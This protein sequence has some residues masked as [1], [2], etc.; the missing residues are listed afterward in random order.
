MIFKKLLLLFLLTSVCSCTYWP[1]KST[2]GFAQN[3]IFSDQYR[4]KVNKKDKFGVLY[5]QLEYSRFRL[6]SFQ[7]TSYAKCH[8]AFI[9]EVKLLHELSCQEYAAGLYFISKKN[10]HILNNKLIKVWPIRNKHQ[11]HKSSWSN[12]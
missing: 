6:I 5:K 1:K 7:R 2:G 9:E 12:K 8:K 10:N 3:Y 11:C 4:K